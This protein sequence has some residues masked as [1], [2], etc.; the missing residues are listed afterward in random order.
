MTTS[1]FF[2][3]DLLNLIQM[4]TAGSR[5][6]THTIRDLGDCNILLQ[7]TVAMVV[8]ILRC[9]L[10]NKLH[11]HC[12]GLHLLSLLGQEM[13]RQWVVC[14]VLMLKE[15][16]PTMDKV[17]GSWRSKEMDLLRKRGAN[18]R[19]FQ[20]PSIKQQEMTLRCMG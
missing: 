10:F 13:G 18:F 5:I 14:R 19:S 12:K 8:F 20:C 3:Q 15:S 16:N 6:P 2:L 1:L 7:T 11:K 17:I 4:Q 9:L